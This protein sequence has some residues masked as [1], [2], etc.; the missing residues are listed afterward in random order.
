MG[1]GE[2]FGE[3][4]ADARRHTSHPIG[5]THNIHVIVHEHYL[6]SNPRSPLVCAHRRKSTA[7]EKHNAPL[8]IEDSGPP[9]MVMHFT[10]SELQDGSSSKIPIGTHLG[11]GTHLEMGVRASFDALEVGRELQC[12]CHLHGVQGTRSLA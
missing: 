11:M 7:N 9:T 10:V 8:G 12:L 5:D 4:V 1:T 6:R 3:G 2:P